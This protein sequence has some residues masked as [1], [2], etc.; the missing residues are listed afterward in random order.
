MSLPFH[1]LQRVKSLR[2]H[3]PEAFKRYPFRVEPPRIGH[4][5]DPPPPPPPGTPHQ[6]LSTLEIGME[7]LRSVAEIEPKAQFLC[8]SKSPDRYDFRAGEKAIRYS[9]SIA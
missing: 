3:I 9:V 7:K 6:L 1:I 5:W 4:Y 2:F 8:E